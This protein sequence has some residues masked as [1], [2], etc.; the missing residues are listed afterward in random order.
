MVSQQLA[1]IKEINIDNLN[2]KLQESLASEISVLQHT[3]HKNVVQLLDIFRVG[4]CTSTLCRVRV[5]RGYSHCSSGI[6]FLVTPCL[7]S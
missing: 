2:K 5:Q 6:H 3:K 1:A 7:P 4:Y